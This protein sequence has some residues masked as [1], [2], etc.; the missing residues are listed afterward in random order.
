MAN[1]RKIKEAQTTETYIITVT[2]DIDLMSITNTYKQRYL[3]LTLSYNFLFM[4]VKT[5]GRSVNGTPNKNSC[6]N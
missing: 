2:R 3:K 5:I 6:N 4:L 1:L